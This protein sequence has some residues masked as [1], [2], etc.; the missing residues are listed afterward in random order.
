MRGLGGDLGGFFDRHRD[1]VGVGGV[2]G[3]GVSWGRRR[4]QQRRSS[5][6]ENNFFGEELEVDSARAWT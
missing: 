4:D 3:L 5:C 2:R 6:S 1:C